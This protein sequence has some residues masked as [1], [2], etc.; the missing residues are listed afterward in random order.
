MTRTS[1]A[2]GDNSGVVNAAN[3]R[4]FVER[5]ERL[6]QEK[7]ELAEDVRAVY[8]EAGGNGF[9][10]KIL[11]KLIAERKKDVDK[12]REEEEI[13]DIYLSAMGMI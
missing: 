8:A 5:I 13:L 4:S 11:R 7:D 12:R 3:L 2:I 9:N 10:K 6:T 1:A